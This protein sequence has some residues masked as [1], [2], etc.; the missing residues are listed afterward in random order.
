MHSIFFM[1]R[2][3]FHQYQC[4]WWLVGWL[5]GLLVG[6]MVCE[7]VCGGFVCWFVIRLVHFSVGLHTNKTNVY[8]MLMEETEPNNSW[9][10]SG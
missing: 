10:R 9:C 8:E 7:L 5:F 1:F 2:L 3:C 4:V 6:L